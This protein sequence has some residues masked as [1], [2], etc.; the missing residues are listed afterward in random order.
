MQRA[1]WQCQAAGACWGEAGSVC[2]R[3]ACT[4]LPPYDLT[5]LPHDHPPTAYTCTCGSRRNCTDV[6]KLGIVSIYCPDGMTQKIWA[7]GLAEYAA[8]A[9]QQQAAP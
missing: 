2:A 1:G 9:A 6:S 7:K 5:L 3:L 4:Q 8:R